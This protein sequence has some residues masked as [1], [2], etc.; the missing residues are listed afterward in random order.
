MLQL[1][2]QAIPNKVG[3]LC[4]LVSNVK[5]GTFTPVTVAAV[6]ISLDERLKQEKIKRE[7]EAKRGKVDNVSFFVGQVKLFGDK[8]LVPEQYRQ[9]VFERLA[10]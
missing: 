4:R 2:K 5:N 7:E 6:P 10:M 3:Y 1:T 9:A 8:F